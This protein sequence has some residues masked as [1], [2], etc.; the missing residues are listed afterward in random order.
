MATRSTPTRC[1]L[2]A[3]RH[4]LRAL[5]QAHGIERWSTNLAQCL[6]NPDDTIYF[7]AQTT[8]HARR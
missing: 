8:T 4:K 7:D 6:A 1:W 5:A 2:G 3:A